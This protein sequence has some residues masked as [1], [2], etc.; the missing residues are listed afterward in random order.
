MDL[1]SKYDLISERFGK[2]K[3]NKTTSQ[4]GI[5]PNKYTHGGQMFRVIKLYFNFEMETTHHNV[6]DIPPIILLMG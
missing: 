5:L 6:F 4:W 3:G 1:L 2:E